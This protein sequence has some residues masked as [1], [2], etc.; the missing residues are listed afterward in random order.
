MQKTKNKTFQIWYWYEKCLLS[1]WKHLLLSSLVIYVKL[2]LCYKIWKYLEMRL[3][4]TEK[5]QK[6]LDWLNLGH[7]SNRNRLHRKT[8]CFWSKMDVGFKFAF[9]MTLVTHLL[10]IKLFWNFFEEAL[11][12]RG[13][14]LWPYLSFFGKIR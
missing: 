3:W 9:S 1:L 7:Q 5:V 6:Y 2:E 13:V 4:N 12:T 10:V 14:A 8:R 11:L